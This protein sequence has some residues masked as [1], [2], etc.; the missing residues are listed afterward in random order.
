MAQYVFVKLREP[1]LSDDVLSRLE[2]ICERLTPQV[3]RGCCNSI[4]SEWPGSPGAYYAI[5]NSDNVSEPAAGMLTIGWVASNEGDEEPMLH[6]VESDGSYAIIKAT[7]KKVSFFSDQF[8]SRTLWYYLDD[9]MLIVSTSQ[10]AIVQFKGAFFPNQAATAW[11]L[12]S[13]CQGPFISWDE[14]IVQV[15]PSFEYV[16]DVAGWQVE[17]SSKSGSG[18]SMP[19][20][21]SSDKYLKQFESQVID[22][23]RKAVFAHGPDEVL[24]PLS[25]GLD[26]RL[27]LALSQEAGAVSRVELVN[28]GIV[29][30]DNVF[31]DKSAAKRIAVTYGKPLLDRFLPTQSDDYNR[32]LDRFVE[33][34]EGRIDHFNAYTDGFSM[35][36][37][38]YQ[39]G[40]RCVLRGDIPFPTA[41]YAGEQSARQQLGL[42]MFEDYTNTQHF[43]PFYGLTQGTPDISL[44]P[45][46]TLIQWRDRLYVNY[47]IPMVVSAFTDLVSGHVENYS[48]MM[49]WSLFKSYAALPDHAKGDKK[50]IRT[51]WQ[52]HDHSGVPAHAQG[53]LSSPEAFFQNDYGR[54]FLADYLSELRQHQRFPD[55]ILA[56]ASTG[57][58][59]GTSKTA[60]RLTKRLRA[61]RGWI[62]RHLPQRLKA[63]LKSKRALNLS[64]QTLAYRLILVDKILKM[65]TDDAER[66][67]TQRAG[68]KGQVHSVQGKL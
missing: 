26:S 6:G 12:S 2:S 61:G 63:Y 57:L 54:R 14:Q 8:G 15:Q 3:I 44:K 25:G 28:W 1:T 24:L 68:I 35:W 30:P 13:G 47:R 23:I 51:L 39:S 64:P 36:D 48:P 37:D 29:Q 56:M 65:Y 33:A 18:M 20:S 66:G 55:P 4:V 50:H 46:E 49:S 17:S 43:L 40:F 42:S 53:S 52:K 41:V 67:A 32:V 59:G 34:S 45:D 38:F 16:L 19:G 5:Q 11:F 58:E 22:T 27:L 9:Q 62:S 31:D 10:R 7:S 21:G 60:T